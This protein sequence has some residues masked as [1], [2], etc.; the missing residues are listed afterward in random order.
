MRLCSN[1]EENTHTGFFFPAQ[2]AQKVAGTESCYDKLSLTPMPI[3]TQYK[4]Q[5]ITLL[6]LI[7]C[8]A[9]TFGSEIG[10]L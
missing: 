4:F 2:I 6:K 8:L 3:Q 7:Y 1:L 9:M 5:S 10:T